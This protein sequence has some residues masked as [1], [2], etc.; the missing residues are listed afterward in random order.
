M[1]RFAVYS[2]LSRAND[3]STFNLLVAESPLL[4]LEVSLAL[5]DA[6]TSVGWKRPSTYAFFRKGLMGTETWFRL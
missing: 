4:S 6:G 1:R 2:S 3:Y 5:F